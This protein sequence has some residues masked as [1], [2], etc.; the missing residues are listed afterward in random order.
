MSNK[1][2]DTKYCYPNT[3]VLV[4]KL[5]INDCRLWID[6]EREITY[7]RN[8]E[9]DTEPIKGSFDATHLKA[10][11][12]YLFQDMYIWA[13][14]FRVVDIAK[15]DL[16]CRV[17]FI[18]DNLNKI[19]DELKNDDYLINTTVEEFPSKLAY[20]FSEINVVHPFR[21]GNGRS[22]RAFARLLAKVCGY[23]LDLS[24]VTEE[25]MNDA[26]IHSYQTLD[27]SKFTEMFSKSLTPIPTEEQLL[28]SKRVLPSNNKALKQLI[29]IKTNAKY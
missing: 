12:K 13:G 27:V 28:F 16:F 17:Q 25:E 10:I 11:H 18:D 20:Y 4:N 8:N 21:E 9:L 14:K 24:K 26:S 29:E 7:Q 6:I 3:S 23:F 2:W 22:Q 5:N 1:T 15:S 19:F